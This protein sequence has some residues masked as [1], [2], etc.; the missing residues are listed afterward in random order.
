[1]LS[2][3]IM[4]Y[5][6]RDKTVQVENPKV[7]I[8]PIYM[9]LIFKAGA[10]RIDINNIETT[11]EM[12]L[13]SNSIRQYFKNT[14]LLASRLNEKLGRVDFYKLGWNPTIVLS[15]S[16]NINNIS[17]KIMKLADINIEIDKLKAY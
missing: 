11:K 15:V 8:I 5:T 3:G 2:T 13:I 17:A 10:D 9:G 6:I 16:E 1:M 14:G 12:Q 4:E 7:S